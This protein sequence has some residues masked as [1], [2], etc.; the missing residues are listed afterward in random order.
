MDGL[1]QAGV[2][3]ALASRTPTPH[4]ASA[5]LDKLGLRQRFHRWAAAGDGLG[6]GLLGSRAMHGS[7]QINADV[8]K[9]QCSQQMPACR[10][11][12]QT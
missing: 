9:Q 4:V 6:R 8:C 7:T 3:L 12:H 11:G 1:R 10:P 5:F 2:K